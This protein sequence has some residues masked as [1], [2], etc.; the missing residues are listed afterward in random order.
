MSDFL[1]ASVRDALTL[2]AANGGRIECITDLG[3]F[4]YAMGDHPGYVDG[5]TVEALV[6]RRFAR[7]RSD[8]RGVGYVVL[9]AAG[10]DA[11][12]ETS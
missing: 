10:A 1:P 9:T 5:R 6:G 8:A 11:I 3:G 4:A 7:R 12:R 2:I